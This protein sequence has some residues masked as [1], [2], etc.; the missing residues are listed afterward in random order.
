MPR[1]KQYLYRQPLIADMIVHQTDNPGIHAIAYPDYLYVTYIKKREMQ[2]FK[3]IYRP[4]DMENFE[5]SV[6]TLYTPYALFD[7]NGA[8]VSSKSLLYE[9]TWS[10]NKIAELL[11]VDYVP[12]ASYTPI[13]L[14]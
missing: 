10:K 13:Y 14:K 9:G 5:T 8:V 6:V 7:G 11:P 12:S 3:D 4:L 1:Y 2:E